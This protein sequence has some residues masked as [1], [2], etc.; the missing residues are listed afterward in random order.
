MIELLKKILI[1]VSLRIIA[2]DK[3]RLVQI[4]IKLCIIRLE[5]KIKVE[6]Q[7]T[8]IRHINSKHHNSRSK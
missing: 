4:K 3:C 6:Q 7:H 2:G 8:I 1:Q 5:N